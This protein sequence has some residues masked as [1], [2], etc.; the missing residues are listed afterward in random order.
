MIPQSGF[1]IAFASNFAMRTPKVVQPH[2][3]CAGPYSNDD[4]PR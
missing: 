2:T 4:N 3:G 1:E